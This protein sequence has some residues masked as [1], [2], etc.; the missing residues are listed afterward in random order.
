MNQI[1]LQLYVLMD[2]DFVRVSHMTI[3]LFGAL[4]AL[5]EFLATV[6]KRK[7]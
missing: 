4:A 3:A 1:W 7:R 2:L 5:F 6:H